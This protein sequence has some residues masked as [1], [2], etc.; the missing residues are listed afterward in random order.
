[1]GRNDAVLSFHPTKMFFKRFHFL[2]GIADA[3]ASGFLRDADRSRRIGIVARFFCSFVKHARIEFLPLD[4]LK[5]KEY[6][7][8][9]IP[10]ILSSVVRAEVS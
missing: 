4:F 2:C 3:G 8:R 1:M 5:R 7:I 9:Y 10:W 6:I